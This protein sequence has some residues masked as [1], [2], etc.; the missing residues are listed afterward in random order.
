V[1]GFADAVRLWD[2]T[3]GKQLNQFPGEVGGSTVEDWRRRLV[4]S[5]A[6]SPDGRSLA[7]A[8]GN[9]TV[10]VYEVATG[11]L[12]SKLVGHHGRVQNVVFSAD[13]RILATAGVDLTALIWDMTGRTQL[14]TADPS[15]NELKALWADLAGD[16]AAR[17]FRAIQRMAAAPGQA[18]PFLKKQLQPASV[19]ID[20]GRLSQL[21]AD[22]DSD[23]FAVRNQAAAELEKLGESAEPALRQALTGRPSLEVRRRVEEMLGKIEALRTPPPSP[24]RL[25]TLRALE[26]LERTATPEAGKVLEH[27]GKGAPGA[28]LTEEA[29]ASWQRLATPVPASP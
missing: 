4:L 15:P 25:C 20:S 27:L 5:V 22:L 12:R 18:I 26:V 14:P 7:T 13:G 10:M 29:R 19:A 28:W 11:K 9:G 6:F 8:E 21:V 24:E 16:D 23:R 3:S 17:A 2:V 1:T